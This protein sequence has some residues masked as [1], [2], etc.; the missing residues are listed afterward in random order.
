MEKRKAYT[1]I[2][3]DFFRSTPE[4]AITKFCREVEFDGVERLRNAMYRDY[5]LVEDDIYALMYHLSKFRIEDASGWELHQDPDSFIIIAKKTIATKEILC[6]EL[7]NGEIIRRE[8]TPEM[9]AIEDYI[10][11]DGEVSYADAWIDPLQEQ[12][13]S[14]W[15]E[16][17]TT[18]YRNIISSYNDLN[19][20]TNN[21]NIEDMKTFET[22]LGTVKL[23]SISMERSRGYGQYNIIIDLL[24]EGEKDRVKIHST[25]SE[26]WDDYQDLETYDEREEFLLNRLEYLVERH[27]DDYI[28]SK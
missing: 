18:E 6:V 26:L 2:I 27:I 28:S 14:S 8:M 22:L 3:V 15:F 1:Q 13:V 17:D 5:I 4:I 25:D 19:H 7:Q 21:N 20:N 23:I 24:F 16:Y 11:E 9:T 10:N 12:I